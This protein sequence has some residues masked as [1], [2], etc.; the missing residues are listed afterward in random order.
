MLVRCQ[1]RG[2]Q[3]RCKQDRWLI[4]WPLNE[5]GLGGGQ[6]TIALYFKPG[7]FVLSPYTFV[8]KTSTLLTPPLVCPG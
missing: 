6:M 4:F 5:M 3:C 7:L 2:G 8:S 1:V